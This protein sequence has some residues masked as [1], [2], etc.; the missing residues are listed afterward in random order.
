MEL[1]AKWSWIG[2]E[3]FPFQELSAQRNQLLHPSWRYEGIIIFWVDL[4]LASGELGWEEED[5]QSDHF[6][7]MSSLNN[8]FLGALLEGL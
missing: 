2:R 7:L 1:A 3:S 5:S 8:L 6:G 4:H